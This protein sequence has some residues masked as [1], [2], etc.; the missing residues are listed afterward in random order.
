MSES[1]R[2]ARPSMIRVL[3]DPTEEMKRIRENPVFWGALL[4][5]TLAGAVLYGF[6]MYFVAQDPALWSRMMGNAEMPGVG[7]EQLK[8]VTMLVSAVGM[9]F[10]YPVGLLI[11]AF[12]L[13]FIVSL[14]QGEATYRQLF[15]LQAHLGIFVLL[16]LLVNFA[17]TA[18]FGLNPMYPPTSLAAFVEAEGM[19][20][21]FLMN[22]E[23]FNIWS[24]V[25]LAIGLKEIA[26]LSKG[27]AWT[28]AVLY[29]GLFALLA[30]GTSGLASI[31]A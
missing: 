6:Q 4:L 11:G 31:G 14:F 15:S 24:T 25:V 26:G 1:V 8:T 7:Q 21:G 30:A 22:L 29:W 18:L 5:V 3:L 28:V 12:V 16:G 10:T 17:G 9:L 13:W 2:T 19:L 23:V 27:K 20:E